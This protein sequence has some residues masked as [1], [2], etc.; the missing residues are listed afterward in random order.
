M[1][2]SKA[3]IAIIFFCS[4]IFFW[5]ITACN[6][7]SKIESSHNALDFYKNKKPVTKNEL[8]IQYY[9]IGS[10]LI[11]YNGKSVFTDPCLS[12]PSLSDVAFGKIATDTNLIQLLN[13]Q[14]QEVE[15]TLIGH[16][17]YDHLL[18]LPYL[19]TQLLPKESKVVGC[20]SALNLIESTNITQ[21]YVVAN[22]IKGDHNKPGEW[23]FNNDSTVRTMVFAGHHPPQIA[24]IIKFGMGK[25][26]KALPKI[27][28]KASKWKE[29]ET[30]TFLI[31]FLEAKQQTIEKRVFVQTS[32]GR[33]P[34]GMV[35]KAILKEKAIDVAII[36]ADL[37]RT[38]EAIDYL[39]AGHYVVVH[40]E[41]FF[42]SKLL[43]A[44]PFSK[45]S[46]NK[47]EAK[48]DELGLQEQVTI[49]LPGEFM[50]F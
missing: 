10:T 13:P 6:S 47:I 20:Q 35:P 45:R 25:V 49:P 16:A 41:N 18:D 2:I 46:M 48:I 43:K 5:I 38:F 33:F 42:K 19:A 12:N 50:I 15:F 28:V 30:Y 11:S 27:P 39:K 26:K 36:P 3:C 44:E 14:L 17:H 21:T 23:I 34:R 24:G 40:W 9:G 7:T 4:I 29:G 22:S 32:S 1:Q 8:G 31:D 37:S